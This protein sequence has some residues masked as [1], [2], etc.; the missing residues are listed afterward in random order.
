MKY[1]SEKFYGTGIRNI[2]DVISFEVGELRNTDIFDTLIESILKDS[3]FR[4]KLETII[5]IFEE[6]IDLTFEE[7][8]DWDET[9]FIVKDEYAGTPVVKSFDGEEMIVNIDDEILTLT[10]LDIEMLD[11]IY[12][13]A[14]NEN[15]DFFKELVEEINKV[16]NKNLKYA[17]WLCDTKEDVYRYDIDG[18]LKD[19]DIDAYLESDIV[20]SDIGSDGKLYGYEIYPEI[21]YN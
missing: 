21:V 12:K 2:V 8:E 9:G 20:L 1:R 10:S 16:T 3:P 4:K 18:D 6:E 15:V 11:V 14:S 13:Y 19:E 7:N 17:L 5:R